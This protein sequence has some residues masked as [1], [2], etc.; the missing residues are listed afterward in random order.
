MMKKICVLEDD[1][2]IRELLEMIF[3]S[4]GFDVRAFSSVT[5]FFARD[6]SVIPD[7]FL[8]DVMLPDGNGVDVCR[9]LHSLKDTSH[10]PVVMMSANA[11]SEQIFAKCGATGF[12]SKPFDIAY[13][14][15]TVN[16]AI[17]A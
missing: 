2:D 15:D 17:Y 7:V 5:D 12:I 11:N 3:V 10:I 14:L 1:N 9:E 4:A 8:L 16:E 13:M 6:S